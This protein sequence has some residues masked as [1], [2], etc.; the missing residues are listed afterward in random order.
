MWNLKKAF[1]EILDVR[2]GADLTFCDSC[3]CPL[4]S[5]FLTFCKTKANTSV[6]LYYKN[7]TTR[8]PWGCW[9]VKRRL[10]CVISR[11]WRRPTHNSWS[12]LNLH[13]RGRQWV[14]TPLSDHYIT[15]SPM[16]LTSACN[17]H[18]R[19]HVW[20]EHNPAVMLWRGDFERMGLR[21]H[22][23]V[24][25]P[26]P[27]VAV[28]LASSGFGGTCVLLLRSREMQCS[29]KSSDSSCLNVMD[30]NVCITGTT[31][32]VLKDALWSELHTT[33]EEYVCTAPHYTQSEQPDRTPGIETKLLATSLS[34]FCEPAYGQSPL[35]F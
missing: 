10:H 24:A 12:I 7:T 16:G 6:Y 8:Q 9:N 32:P 5:L 21:A 18:C 25:R 20:S 34:R 22:R 17:Y 31:S 1:G 35:T 3:S 33:R 15:V 29:P 30:V 28:L 13:R 14:T 27:L 11:M 26:G 2:T 23:S 4:S 19:H